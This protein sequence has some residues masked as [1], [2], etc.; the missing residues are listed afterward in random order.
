MVSSHK[1]LMF[2]LSHSSYASN[3]LQINARPRAGLCADQSTVMG[4]YGSQAT[5]GGWCLMVVCTK[6]EG[7]V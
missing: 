2:G 3:P 7:Q 1:R 4:L 5:F 6:Q